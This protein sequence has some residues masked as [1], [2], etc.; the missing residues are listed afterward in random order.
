MSTDFSAK[1]SGGQIPFFQSLRWRFILIFTAVAMVPLLGVGIFSLI[2]AEQVMRERIQDDMKLIVHQQQ[3]AVL[4]WENE[5]QQNMASLATLADIQSLSEERIKSVLDPFQKL[6]PQFENVFVAGADGMI[7]YNTLQAKVSLADR[8]YFKAAIQGQVNISDVLLSKTTGNIIV[9]PAAPIRSADGKIIGVVAG[10]VKTDVILDLLKQAQIGETGDA[11]LVNRQ[12]LLVSPSRFNKVYKERKLIDGET[13]AMALNVG[14]DNKMGTQTQA[15]LDIAGGKMAAG[16]VKAGE[17]RNALGN[18]VVGAYMDI[19]GTNMGLVVEQDQSEA[20]EKVYAL[21][22][23][24]VFVIVIAAAAVIGL[25]ALVA[26]NITRP[27]IAMT[28][29]AQVIATG[30]IDVEVTHQ[31]KDEIG[32]LA[33]AFRQVIAYQQEMVAAALSLAQNDLRVDIKPQSERDRL[34]VA[35]SKMTESLRGTIRQVTQNANNLEATST[36]LAHAA[37]QTSAAVSQITLTMQQVA[38]GINQETNSIN[39]TTAS[40]DMLSRAIQGVAKGAQEQASSISQAAHL[41]QRLNDASNGIRSGSNQQIDTI[42]QTRDVVR[43]LAQAVDGIRNGAQE[44]SKGLGQA[45]AAGENLSAALN[46]VTEAANQVAGDSARAAKEAASGVEIVSRSSKGMDRVRKTNEQL[47]LR[48]SE[49]GTRTGQI[50]AIIETIDDIAAQ[51]NLLALNAAIE[52]ARAGEHGRGFAVVADEVRK[53]AE[54]SALA[55][56]EIADMIKAI[57]TGA[58]EAVKAMEQAVT[59]VTAAAE[60]TGQARESFDSIATATTQAAH[61]LEGITKAINGMEK[62][63]DALNQAVFHANEIA[64]RNLAAASEMASLNQTVVEATTKVDTVSTQTA[65]SI[66]AMTALNSNMSASLDTVSAVVEE[67]S[68]A[69][70]EMAASAN[71]VSQAFENIASVSE[72]NSAAVE[73]VSASTEE[74]NAQVE[75]LTASAASLSSM[76]VSLKEL[77]ATFK[78]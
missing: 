24:L 52:A 13:T 3:Q 29:S 5:R 43:K 53:L 8:A 68:A 34:G 27:I 49:L 61:R 14:P 78:L 20:F 48:I 17:Y 54:K 67:N 25:V 36:Q 38:S 6:N 37:S 45:M 9:V 60:L 15:G 57:Q 16:E 2:E 47:A 42:A 40:M 23:V 39:T 70:E 63:R 22:M 58:D 51:T 32:S 1:K 66:E 41:M 31:S 69:T 30:D 35:F 56:K 55:T 46:D 18:Q 11:Y 28:R 71:E 64:G 72:E 73:E 77:V 33:N 10:S 21:R 4:N 12:G 26:V 65:A 75:E 44:Q 74:M 7:I 50:G 19:E 59:E 62:A 76:A